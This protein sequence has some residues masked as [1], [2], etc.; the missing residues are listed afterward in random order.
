[1]LSHMQHR[2]AQYSQRKEL[3]AG[4]AEGRRPCFSFAGS[5]SASGGAEEQGGLV[6]VLVIISPRVSPPIPGIH[7]GFRTVLPDLFFL[8]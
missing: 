1:M 3:R 6:L 8:A 2:L 7:Q 5:R 4:Q